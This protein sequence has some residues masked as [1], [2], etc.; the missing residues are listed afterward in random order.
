M[1]NQEELRKYNTLRASHFQYTS[2]INLVLLDRNVVFNGIGWRGFWMVPAL[3]IKGLTQV[4]L[5][6]LQLTINWVAFPMFGEEYNLTWSILNTTLGCE[7]DYKLHLDHA[8]N[9]FSKSDFWKAISGSNDCSNLTPCQIH[10][11]TLCFL[12]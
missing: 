10:N 1:L 5:C 8:T 7:H 12:H 9:G 2:T 3:G 11:P 4:F 6:T